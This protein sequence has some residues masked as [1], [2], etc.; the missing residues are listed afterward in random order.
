MFSKHV[1]KYIQHT[2]SI[3]ERKE[4]KCWVCVDGNQ[5]PSSH[6]KYKRI[7]SFLIGVFFGGEVSEKH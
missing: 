2:L 5:I 3:T 7:C 4:L 1:R 6:D